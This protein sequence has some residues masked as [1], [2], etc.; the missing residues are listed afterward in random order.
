MFLSFSFLHS[1]PQKKDLKTVEFITKTYKL[2]YIS[3]WEAKEILKPYVEKFTYSSHGSFITVTV[4]KKNLKLFEENLF[5]IDVPK[6][7]FFLRFT[8][9]LHQKGKNKTGKSF[10]LN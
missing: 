2:K 7:T 10:L 5:K 9:S 1:S 3:P 8:L 6:K 4:R